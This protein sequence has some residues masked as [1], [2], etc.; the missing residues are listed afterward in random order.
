[1]NTRAKVLVV[2]GGYAGVMAAR[3]L[4]RAA[5]GKA[6]VTLVSERPEL[7]ERIRLHQAAAGRG[8]VTW[9]LETLLRGTGARVHLGTVQRL[10]LARRRVVLPGQSLE[11][12]FVVLA[13]GS[14]TGAQVP[15]VA[16]HAHRLDSPASARALGAALEQRPGRLVVVGGGL[17]AIEA[18]CEL[19]PEGAAREAALLCRGAL[20]EGALGEEAVAV[21]RAALRRR[22]V[23][24][25]EGCAV[26]AVEPGAVVLGSGRLPAEVVVWAAGFAPGPLAR[27]AGLGCDAQGRLLVTQALQARGAPWLFGAGDAV[28]PE[29]PVGAPLHASCKVALPMA[30]SVADSLARVLAGGEP[31]PFHFGDSGVCVS[32]GRGDG[33]VELRTAAGVP[34]RVLR[35]RTAAWV[36]ERVCRFTIEVMTSPLLQRT[37]QVYGARGRAVL[38]RAPALP[39]ASVVP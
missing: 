4:A 25:R 28:R 21:V 17:T 36:K 14:S 19:Q 34:T 27:E 13:T 29:V 1:M 3:R 26:A 32:L 22:R 2:G 33:V 35:G 5:A 38:E 30:A 16:E 23:E 8:N 10:D 31:V 18:M 24:V 39:A 6:E 11:A 12:D 9:R 7:V 15:G 37:F 20:G